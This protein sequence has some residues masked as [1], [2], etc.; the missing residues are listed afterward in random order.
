[1]KYFD[2]NYEFPLIQ[3]W[4]DAPLAMQ[5]H[6]FINVLLLNEIKFLNGDKNFKIEMSFSIGYQ[7]V[8]LKVG[9]MG[10]EMSKA[11][12]KE[13]AIGYGYIWPLKSA[14]VKDNPMTYC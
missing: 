7:L 6:F 8:D 11:C 2:F 13:M 9:F 1:M 3:P 4:D 12:D 10:I 5:A 14:E